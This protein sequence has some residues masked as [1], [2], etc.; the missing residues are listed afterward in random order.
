MGARFALEPGRG[1]RALPVRPALAGAVFGVLGVIAAFTFS[2]GV[3]DVAAHPQRLGVVHDLTLY[4]GVEGRDGE[5][6]LPAARELFTAVAGVD[7]VRGVNDTR[8]AVAETGG[9]PLAVLSADPIGEPLDVVVTE[10]R[11]PEAAGE[12]LLGP[13]SARQLGTGV[14]DTVEVTGTAGED[15]LTVVGVGLLPELS[16]NRYT[17]GGLVTAATYDGLFDGFRFHAGFVDLEP[18]VSL[19]DVGQ[20]LG[21]AAASVP[22]GEDIAAEPVE[23]PSPVAEL[24]S[25]RGLPVVLAVFLAVLALGAVGH[26]LATAVRRRRHEMAVLRAVGMTRRQSRVVVATQATVLALAGL[27]I[28]V[29]L[30]VALGRVVWRYVADTTPLFYVPPVDVTALALVVPA[31]LLAANLLAA[32]PSHRAASMRVGHVLRAE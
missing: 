3:D 27:V 25:I 6:V 14:G 9:G 18:G 12:I 31:A 16:H 26:A 11:R 15:A 23:L 17:D 30:G 13:D 2:D 28:G 32:W 1:R 8:S 4:V 10:G 22:G 24:S 21:E 20:E 7:G 19:D 5:D 29:P